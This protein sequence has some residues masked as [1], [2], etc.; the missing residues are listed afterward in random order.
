[1]STLI[2]LGA[3]AVLGF[4]VGWLTAARR[5]SDLNAMLR[6]ADYLAGHDRLTGLPNR[7]VAAQAFTGWEVIGQPITVVLLDLDG[8]KQVNDV[9]GHYVGDEL[10]RVVAERLAPIA[11]ARGGLAARL[12]GDEFLILLPSQHDADVPIGQILAAVAEPVVLRG[13]EGTIVIAPRASA[14]IAAFDGEHGTFDTLLHHADVALYHAKGRQ[15]GFRTY[16]PPMRM[17]RNASRHGPRLRDTRR[18]AAP[19]QQ[20]GP[21]DR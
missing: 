7:Y 19:G 6:V 2:R 4:V 15:G 10:L 20:D 21:V 16:R 8:F 1:M 12:A 18:H 9:H 5:V 11:T 13:D 3:T 17:P 14:G